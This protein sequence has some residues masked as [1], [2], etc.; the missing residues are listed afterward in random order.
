LLSVIFFT[1]LSLGLQHGLGVGVNELALL[2]NRLPVSILNSE[3]FRN[4]E[5]KQI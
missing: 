2:Q 3:L 4:M 1:K 5:T